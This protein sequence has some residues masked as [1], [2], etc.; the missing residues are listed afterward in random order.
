ME[1]NAQILVIEDNQSFR[2]L[3]GHLLGK[4]YRVITQP[5]GIA[6]MKWLSEGN[7]PDLILLDLELPG[8]TGKDFL[9]GLKTSGFYGSIPVMILSGNKPDTFSGEAMKD[10]IFYFEKP[11]DPRKL[12]EKIEQLFL[13]PPAE[14][15]A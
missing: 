5:D 3:I 15:R 11:F 6:A 10:V 9:T 2:Q 12:L 14:L 8:M 4:H 7:Y 1:A 13:P